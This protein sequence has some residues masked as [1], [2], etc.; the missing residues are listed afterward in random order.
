RARSVGGARA[1]GELVDRREALRIGHA[2][3]RRAVG[4][5]RARGS[6]AQG[7]GRGAHGRGRGWDRRREVVAVGGAERVLGN[8][9]V[10]VGGALLEVGEG[11]RDR[12][13]GGSA[14]DVD[15]GRLLAVGRGGAVL[16]EVARV[17]AVGVDAAGKHR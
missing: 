16:P 1:V 2:G 14:A 12:D 5:D 9:P 6:G 13:R 15:G 11:A 17:L 10:V 3:E 8:Q 7:R 4:G